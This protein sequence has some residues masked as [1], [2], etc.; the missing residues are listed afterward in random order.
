MLRQDSTCKDSVRAN[1]PGKENGEGTKSPWESVRLWCE[2]DSQWRREGGTHKREHPRLPSVP[3]RSSKATGN[4]GAKANCQESPC[5]LVGRAPQGG[6]APAQAQQGYLWPLISCV[7][8]S[9]K[10]G[11][12][13]LVTT[14]KISDNKHRLAATVF[15]SRAYCVGISLSSNIQLAFSKSSG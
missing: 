14:S 1:A 7:P 6:V 13:I 4:S 5:S 15:Q 9:W 2:S 11:R 10:S 8:C 12:P 3:G